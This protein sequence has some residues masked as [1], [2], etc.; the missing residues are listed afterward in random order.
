MRVMHERCAGLDVQQK[1]V[2]VCGLMGEAGSE[3]ELERRT[4]ATTTSQLL[5]LVL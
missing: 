3:P 5:E 4:W 1:T 2:V